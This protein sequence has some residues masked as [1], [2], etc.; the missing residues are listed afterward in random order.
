M[1]MNCFNN[2]WYHM[3]YT[4]MMVYFWHTANSW[5]NDLAASFIMYRHWATLHLCLAHLRL[6]HYWSWAHHLR[7][8][9]HRDFC[10]TFCFFCFWN[11]YH[12]SFNRHLL[13]CRHCIHHLRLKVFFS[14]WRHHSTA[15]I[16]SIHKNH[17]I[18]SYCNSPRSGPYVFQFVFL[19][20]ELHV[21]SF[22]EVLSQEV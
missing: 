15:S 9:H 16:I 20:Y 21:E 2:D 22:G 12:F 13:S 1:V 19:V 11:F 7:L 18:L 3:F 17:N 6:R 5:F 4:V 8:R 10:F 14:H